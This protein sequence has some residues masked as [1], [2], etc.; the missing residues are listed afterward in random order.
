MKLIMEN[1][2]RFLQETANKE[3]LE[4]FQKIYEE[5]HDLQATY[6]TIHKG[7]YYDSEGNAY[8]PEE[9][10][11]VPIEDQPEYVKDAPEYYG[12]HSDHPA[13]RRATYSQ[14]QKEVN[15]EKKLMSLYQRFVNQSFFENEVLKFHDLS[16]PAHVQQP[17]SESGL[18]F[19][20]FRPSDYL[21]MGITPG[22]KGKD[23][24]SCHGSTM[25]NL[26]GSYG[27]ILQGFTI[28][29][30]RGDLGS[31]TL[32]TAHKKVRDVHASSGVPKRADPSKVHNKEKIE[33]MKWR[34]ERHIT[35][36]IKRGKEP[37]P[38]MTDEEATE[39][40]NSVVLNAE[41][42]SARDITGRRRSSGMI[43]EIL[44]KHWTIEGWYFRSPAGR[45]LPRPEA[46][47]KMAYEL[48]IDQPIYEVDPSG[49]KRRVSLSDY[50]G[51]EEEIE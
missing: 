40:V 3:F 49:R 41:D 50:F 44:L 37:K 28:F 31:Q 20:D 2:R 25:G 12:R 5:W 32:R 33:K 30:S 23:V 6:G 16:Y 45:G 34:R 38:S 17:W 19:A 11:S 24:M 7:I 43:E 39:I 51:E 35:R 22:F 48:G 21:E 4:E 18:D 13:T 14:T 36:D 8:P 29:A 1:W 47:W 26:R 42:V 46:F 15:I 9:V 10:Q 27:M